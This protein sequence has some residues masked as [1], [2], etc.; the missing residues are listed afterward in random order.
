[1]V[2][3]DMYARL[4]QKL[5]YFSAGRSIRSNPFPLIYSCL[6]PA[7]HSGYHWGIY[8]SFCGNFDKS[9]T[10][11]S[12]LSRCTRLLA[13]ASWSTP[14]RL[15]K[16]INRYTAHTLLGTHLADLE[17][18]I[19]PFS[20]NSMDRRTFWSASIRGTRFSSKGMSSCSYHIPT[21]W[22]QN[23][24]NNRSFCISY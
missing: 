4:T 24:E 12:T 22:S 6:R 11:G 17:R 13:I 15:G 9:A 1:M 23:G 19:V 10:R 2:S 7:D 14:R 5:F 18:S 20:V 8:L 16:T 3:V 21:S